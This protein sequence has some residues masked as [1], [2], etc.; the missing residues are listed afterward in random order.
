YLKD[1]PVLAGPPSA[2]YRLLKF[3]RR[4]RGPVL[5]ASLLLLSLLAGIIGTTWGMI[6]ANDALAVAGNEA[7]QKEASLQASQQSEREAREQ[8]FLALWNQARAN[9]FSRQMGQRLDSLAA[10]ERA[11]G[12]RPDERLRNEA[13]AAMALPDVRR[14]PGWRSRPPGTATVA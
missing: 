8:L 14:V 9:R 5:A 11:A 2:G 10:I 1:E 7:N 6:R 13:I 3:L 4:H 12:I